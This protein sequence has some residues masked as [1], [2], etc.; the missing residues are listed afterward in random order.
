M[1]TP[2]A[3]PV[4]RSSVRT[5]RVG[6]LRLSSASASDPVRSA[7]AAAARSRH[8]APHTSRRRLGNSG[9][10]GFGSISIASAPL[11]PA[12]I[13]RSG[14][15]GPVTDASFSAAACA[16]FARS[17]ATFSSSFSSSLGCSG[18]F[19]RRGFGAGGGS[20]AGGVGDLD[21]GTSS[22]VAR[23]ARS[24]CSV[25]SA[26]SAFASSTGAASVIS[27]STAGVSV[28]SLDAV[29]ASVLSS[30]SALT[31]SSKPGAS[32]PAWESSSWSCS[33]AAAAAAAATL[34]CSIKPLPNASSCMSCCLLS[35][36][37]CCCIIMTWI[38]T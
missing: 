24:C 17:M 31:A 8:A 27:A 9:S 30:A 19:L 38:M 10:N 3:T 6:Y 15:P 12:K 29:S 37:K 1:I 32:S 2:D 26:S 5:A 21:F 34:C 7:S 13:W 35:V 14:L 22:S 28:S 25:V 33:T 11:R 16:I 36:R 4:S 20:G 18:G 23:S